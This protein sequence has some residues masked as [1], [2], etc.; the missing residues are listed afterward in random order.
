M[1]IWNFVEVDRKTCDFVKIHVV[2]IPNVGEPNFYRHVGS[3]NA[4]IEGERKNATKLEK[5]KHQAGCCWSP[6]SVFIGH[7]ERDNMFGLEKVDDKFFTTILERREI[8][9]T[10]YDSIYDFYEGI[11]FDRKTRRHI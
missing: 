1:S 11:G 10:S 7:R 2:K 9:S 3:L 8:T 5:Q 6:T 4:F